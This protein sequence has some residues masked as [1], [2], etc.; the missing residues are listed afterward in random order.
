MLIHRNIIKDL[1]LKRLKKNIIKDLKL[2]NEGKNGE[3]PSPV[4]LVM[5]KAEVKYITLNLI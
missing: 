3:G 4:N 1:K 2:E 5:Q